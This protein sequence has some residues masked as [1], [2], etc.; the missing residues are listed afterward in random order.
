MANTI[1]TA[2]SALGD[3]FEVAVLDSNRV[4]ALSV[5]STTEDTPH[6]LAQNTTL[7]SIFVGTEGA[8]VLVFRGSAFDD[9]KAW[10]MHPGYHPFSVIGDPR[11]LQFRAVDAATTVRILEN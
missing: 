7:I 10:H 5:T 3:S 2:V 11:E 1:A 8:G 4:S 6:V 9:T